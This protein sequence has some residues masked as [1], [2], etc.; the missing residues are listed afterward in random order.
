MIKAAF[1]TTVIGVA[2]LM[3]AFANA[4][5][6]DT[7]AQAGTKVAAVHPTE[8]C[9]ANKCGASGGLV[10][11]V[12][13]GG[14]V[15]VAWATSDPV[16]TTFHGTSNWQGQ[17]QCPAANGGP[18]VEQ[19]TVADVWLMYS[20][21]VDPVHGACRLL[22]QGQPDMPCVPTNGHTC[23][24]IINPQDLVTCQE[25][26]MLN[27]Q[28][29]L[30]QCEAIVTMDP[31]QF[32]QDPQACPP[33]FSVGLGN[34]IQLNWHSWGINTTANQSLTWTPDDGSITLIHGGAP[35]MVQLR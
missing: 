23:G 8:T 10:N 29:R 19:E 25:L 34:G 21:H 11:P 16:Y 28:V 15:A 3:A 20:D 30:N 32:E 5:S 26:K 2:C 9:F 7:L 6:I 18:W 4:Q 35:A 17:H 1:I 13:F 31:I 33:S 24:P 14:P 12:G 22:V 27:G